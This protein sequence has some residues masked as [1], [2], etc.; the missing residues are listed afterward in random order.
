VAK[1]SVALLV[2]A[3]GLL[4]LS[5]VDWGAA[6]AAVAPVPAATDKAVPV[7]ERSPAE[8]G[9]DLFLTK[10]C[11]T[12][13]RYEGLST[14]RILSGIDGEPADWSLADAG[15]APDLTHYR[16][17]P[18]FVRSWLKDPRAIRPNTAMPDLGLRQEE[19]EALLAF[20]AADDGS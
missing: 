4:A 9:R 18:G 5:F 6:A 13:H 11:A 10:G 8:R 12:C 14:T 19:I 2:L 20:L 16:P 15:G 3:L 1:A 7:P 17:D